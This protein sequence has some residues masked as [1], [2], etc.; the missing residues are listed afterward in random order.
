MGKRKQI[1]IK[2]KLRVRIFFDG[3]KTQQLNDWFKTMINL[4]DS[5]C[6]F[7]CDN[8]YNFAILINTTIPKKLTCSTEN[9]IGLAWEP[10]KL[11]KLTPKF[12]MFAKNNISKYYISETNRQNLP[13][14]FVKHYQYLLHNPIIDNFISFNDKPKH[15]SFILSG[16]AFMIGHRYRHSLFNRL[17]KT[18]LP[19]DFYGRDMKVGEYLGIKDDRIKGPFKE[20]ECYIDY[21]FSIA[22]EN[23]ISGFY[24]SEKYTNCI[25]NNTIPVYC[26]SSKIQDIFGENFGIKMIGNITKDVELMTDISKN[27]EKYY[28]DLT[29]PLNEIKSGKA[30]IRNILPISDN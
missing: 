9:T 13:P 29:E 10:L 15:M 21:K 25:I 22:I 23:C 28:R 18:D 17:I 2:Q 14:C 3:Y 11:L 4:A 19:I 26:G 16:K 8:T 7:V 20:R 12:I 6:T 5:E 24:V 1:K 27:P 30:N